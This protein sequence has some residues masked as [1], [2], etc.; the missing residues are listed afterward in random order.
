MSGM[1]SKRAL[2]PSGDGNMSPSEHNEAILAKHH[3]ELED[4]EREIIEKVEKIWREYD[5]DLSGFLEMDECKKFFDEALQLEQF[6]D[7]RE[8]AAIKK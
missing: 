7:S 4:H 6:K 3:N 1:N 8:L 5:K 2:T